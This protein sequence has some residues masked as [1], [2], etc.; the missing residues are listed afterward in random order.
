[1]QNKK[2]ITKIQPVRPGVKFQ[3]RIRFENLSHAELGALLFSLDLPGGCNHKLGMGK[4]LGLG[5]V[6][7]TPR[8]FL[9][10]RKKRYENLSFEWNNEIDES[11]RIPEF[12]TAF[13]QYVLNRIEPGEKM[14]WNTERLRELKIM[15]DYDKGKKSEL[16]GKVRYMEITGRNKNEFKDRPILPKPSNVR[17]Y[18]YV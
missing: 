15:L 4:P 9:S 17:C 16:Q 8:L 7:I 12:T 3:G 5:S 6:K 18:A 10:D 13:E 2:I 11:D 14:L 1:M